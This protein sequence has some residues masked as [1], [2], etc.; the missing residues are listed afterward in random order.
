MA[1]PPSPEEVLIKLIDPKIVNI[2]KILIKNTNLKMR[3]SEISSESKVPISSTHRILKKLESLEIVKVE[4]INKL[5]L[6]SLAENKTSEFLRS[7]IKLLPSGLEFFLNQV[8]NNPNVEEVILQGQEKEN[9]ASLILLG[10]NI[11]LTYIK[12]IA[13]ETYNKFKYNILYLA[14][15]KDQYEQMK[16]IGLYGYNQ[17]I[18]FSRKEA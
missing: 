15:T 4:E 3:M 9:S 6:Y 16:S 11:D 14:L 7:I 13:Q 17:K 8:K 10:E 5:K 1:S 18:L 2:L 12:N